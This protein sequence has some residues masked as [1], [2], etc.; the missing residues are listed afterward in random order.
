MQTSAEGYRDLAL[1]IDGEWIG[2]DER[3][4]VDVVNPT[5]GRSLGGV[6]KA[7]TADLDRALQ[8]AR[9]TFPA[10]RATP[11]AE[12]AAV[13]E[14]AAGLLEDRLESIARMM[15]VEEG[16]TLAEARG[17][18]SFTAGIVRF[19][20]GEAF[21]TFGKVVPTGGLGQRTVVLSEPIG[22]VAAFT[23]WNYPLTVPARKIAAAL[24]AGC[25]MVIKPA[26]ETPATALEL[27]RA[28]VDAGLPAGVLGVV[29]G[30]PAHISAHLIR[31]P[32]IRKG[33]FNGS[34][35][36]G[37]Q[38]VALAG[39]GVKPAMLELGGHA[40]VLVFDDVDVEAVATA[41]VGSKFHNNGQ[42]CGSPARFYVHERVHD[43]FVA[44]FAELTAALRVGD[45][46][47]AQT[48][49]GPLA[50]TRRIA[51]MERLVTDAVDMGA[52]LLV[53]GAA[54][55]GDGYFWQPTVL[56]GVPEEAML[57]NEEPFG[58]IAVTS[59]FS[60]TEEVV[61]AANR[62]PFGLGSYVFT[63]SLATAAQVPA[64]L[65]AGMVSVNAFNLGGVDTFFGGV[66]ESGYGSEGG[67][68][69]VAGY[70]TPKLIT[71]A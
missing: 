43:A 64:A 7:T 4:V 57:M 34:T 26:E 15:T 31:S 54:V 46:L 39:E 8:A 2:A 28:L 52:E 12:R 27:A 59:T 68:E 51:A 24:A 10:W 44:R 3:D 33:T 53:G 47:D 45:P 6:P 23:P 22:P 35:P 62:L 16:K 29:F 11:P 42:S 71:Q 32:V 1:L 18:V 48:Q 60:S 56:A 9:R 20:A 61:A 58:P 41:A 55:P 5:T 66:K 63:G 30:D 50:N 36:V 69:A 49:V 70:L 25:T 19:L 13:L 17:E 14:R 21:R 40:P 65:E 67:P 37:K 38:V